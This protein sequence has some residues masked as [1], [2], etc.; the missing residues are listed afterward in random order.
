MATP[1][2]DALSRLKNR[3]LRIGPSGPQQRPSPSP[4]TPPANRKKLVSSLLPKRRPGEDKT[5]ER[6]EET[7]DERHEDEVYDE[8]TS[9]SS[10]EPSST[11]E[12][13][14][15]LTG[16]LNGRRRNLIRRPGTLYS[17]SQQQQAEVA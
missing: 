5:V 1:V 2:P 8:E 15:G 4:V 6:Q 9:P 17:R 3:R 14:K 16:L 13:D 7:V 11:T 12:A 10:V